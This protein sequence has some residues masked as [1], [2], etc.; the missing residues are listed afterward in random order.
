MLRLPEQT[1]VYEEFRM[2]RLTQPYIP[3]FLA[4]R[5]VSFLV[6]LL[7]TLKRTR[8]DLYPQV[9][10]VDGNGVLHTRGFGMTFVCS[11]ACE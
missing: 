8:P 5:E 1:V 10:L 11:R 9:V 6:D 3:G 2:I 4:F 7:E